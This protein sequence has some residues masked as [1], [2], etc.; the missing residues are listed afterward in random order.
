MLEGKKAPKFTLPALN[1]E[2]VSLEDYLGKKVVLYFYPKD[3]T[4]GWSTEAG[5]FN[6]LLNDFE[7]ANTVV[8]GISKDSLKS[9][10]KF[11]KKLDL[12]F[13]LLSDV[14]TEVHKL[15]DTWQ[16]KKSFG[17]EYYGTVRST[18]VIDEEGTLIK[19]F[20]KVKA[21]GHAEKVLEFIEYYEG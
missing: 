8:L 3:N 18:F 21:K 5:E 12:N 1:D 7:E 9:H 6:D 2:L 17:K 4:P 20:R 19:E 13:K 10:E 15:Y 16:L 14:D 11:S